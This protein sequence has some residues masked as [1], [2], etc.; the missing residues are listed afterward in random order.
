MNFSINIDY[1]ENIKKISSVYLVSTHD[2]H[3]TLNILLVPTLLFYRLLANMYF[4][5]VLN[6][7][8]FSPN[9]NVT[10]TWDL[11]STMKISN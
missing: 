4:S 9:G 1:I 7:L 3:V 6:I 2:S 5:N 8:Q 10:Q 11:Y